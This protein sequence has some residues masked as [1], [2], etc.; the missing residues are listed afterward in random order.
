M[1]SLF[2]RSETQKTLEVSQGAWQKLDEILESDKKKERLNRFR[3]LSIAATIVLL[4]SAFVLFRTN[5][6]SDYHLENLNVT[7]FNHLYLSEDIVMLNQSFDRLREINTVHL[8]RT[9]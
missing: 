5:A 8:D 2:R 1:D 7:K 6:E 9:D 3:L 4:V